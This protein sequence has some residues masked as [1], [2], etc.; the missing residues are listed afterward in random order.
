V[1]KERNLEVHRVVQALVGLGLLGIVAMFAAWSGD[2]QETTRH[3]LEGLAEVHL[4]VLIML[5]YVSLT[6]AATRDEV[7]GS[8]PTAGL[9]S[10]T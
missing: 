2:G 9:M 10:T 5:L 8:V 6:R 4:A 7:S 3:T 1:I